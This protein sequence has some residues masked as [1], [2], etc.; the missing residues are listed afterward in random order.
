MKQVKKTEDHDN[1]SEFFNAAISKF[2]ENNRGFAVASAET[3]NDQEIAV[4]TNGST[5]AKIVYSPDIKRFLLFRGDANCSDNNYTELQS[6]LFEPTGD[7]AADVR[8]ANSVANEFSETFS[9]PAPMNMIPEASRMD[10]QCLTVV[11]SLPI[12]L[13][14][15]EQFSTSPV[16]AAAAMM[17]RWKLSK[18]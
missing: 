9:G 3:K 7:A 10:I 5:N 4:L 11:A 15:L 12:S 14:I 8:E 17:K 16:R 6:Y 18:S 13:A 1:M 2:I